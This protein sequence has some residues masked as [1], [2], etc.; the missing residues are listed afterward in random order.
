MAAASTTV[1]PE[2]IFSGVAEGA[3]TLTF[4]HRLTWYTAAIALP[5]VFTI[6]TT[7]VN[8]SVYGSHATVSVG[9]ALVMSNDTVYT[10]PQSSSVSLPLGT[11]RKLPACVVQDVA[12]PFGY[13]SV[14][15]NLVRIR[16][17][18]AVVSAVFTPV[19]GSKAITESYPME[20]SFDGWYE[21]YVDNTGNGSLEYN[22]TVT[23]V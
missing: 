8:T 9:Y 21:G 20:W 12:F 17:L 22:G 6:D 19:D 2:G 1:P 11:I 18:R 23:V 4:R 13:Y 7:T 10:V 5:A 16:A 15:S 14:N 3:N